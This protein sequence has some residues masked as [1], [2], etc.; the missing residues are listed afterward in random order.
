MQ[1]VDSQSRS[2][3]ACELMGRVQD[4]INTFP[5][6]VVTLSEKSIPD[7]DDYGLELV[8]SMEPSKALACPIEVGLVR[9]EGGSDVYLF[10][11]TWEGIAK[12]GG[13]RTPTKDVSRRVGLY[14]E[15]MRLST[16]QVLGICRAVSAGS[17]KMH[18][19]VFS[20]RLISTSGY[21]QV[22]HHRF[23]MHGIGGWSHLLRAA[24]FFGW[25][26]VLD[27]PYEPW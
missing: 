2:R 9:P 7:D 27:V 6:S 23:S 3:A 8:L 13:L 14:V 21:V 20:G 18:M 5:S 17:V 19:G 25:A 22:G 1:E 12:R 4:W 15:P 16:E 10:L 11:D 24:T 26:D